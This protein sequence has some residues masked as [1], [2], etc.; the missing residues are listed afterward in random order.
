[1]NAQIG[2]DEFLLCVEPYAHRCFQSAVG[3]RI[4]GEKIRDVRFSMTSPFFII[5]ITQNSA[6][7]GNPYSYIICLCL[8]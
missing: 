1:M 2:A 8:L 6:I 4:A 3:N 7:A 5:W